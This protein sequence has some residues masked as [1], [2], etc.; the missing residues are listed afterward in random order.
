MP[1][2]TDKTSFNKTTLWILAMVGILITF[3]VYQLASPQRLSEQ[4][5]RQHGLV[6]FDE[7]RALEPINLISD[8]G[9]S[10][11]MEEFEGQWN[12]LFFGF[13]HCPDIC[14]TTMATL[15]KVNAEAM[16]FPRVWLVTV[17]PHRDTPSELNAYLNK[18]DP[19]FTG[20]T[21]EAR[22]IKAL[23]SQFHLSVG[24]APHTTSTNYNVGHSSSLVLVDAAGRH[25]GYIKAPHTVASLQSIL[26][27]L[28]RI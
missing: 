12:L 21:G 23:A 18:F 22:E 2:D 20:I 13:T 28:S 11:A 16:E 4:E 8:S 1:S 3:L 27:N 24:H 6:L 5:A 17:D 15:A 19:A 10:L 9:Q 7:P 25:A 26:G 14:P